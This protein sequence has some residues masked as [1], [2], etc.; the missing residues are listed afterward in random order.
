MMTINDYKKSLNTTTA[1]DE[2]ERRL[3]DL[4]AYIRSRSDAKELAE[5]F[6]EGLGIEMMIPTII[7]DFDD[8]AGTLQTMAN[9]TWEF[10]AIAWLEDETHR[11]A[12]E[13]IVREMVEEVAIII[14]EWDTEYEDT[15]TTNLIGSITQPP[16]NPS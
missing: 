10:F 5:W 14:K 3:D 1:A 11:P 9:A 15:A 7:G 8:P 4:L 2:S 13:L 16:R 12:L 6:I